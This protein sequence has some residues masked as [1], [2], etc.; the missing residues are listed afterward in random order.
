MLRS[1]D[2]AQTDSVSEAPG[3]FPGG[4]GGAGSAHARPGGRD[5][6]GG[7]GGDPHRGGRGAAARRRLL[8][9]DRRRHPVAAAD[10]A[11]EGEIRRAARRAAQGRGQ[12][13]GGAGGL[14][15][16]AG[17]A[18]DAGCRLRIVRGPR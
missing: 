15:R 12:A 14:A 4:A 5:P 18:G 9:A 3:R 16:S 8:P 17:E 2:K 10:P 11:A 6:Y 13:R 7:D 1:M